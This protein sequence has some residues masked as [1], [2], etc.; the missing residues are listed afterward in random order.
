MIYRFK[1][2]RGL[3]RGFFVTAI[4]LA[5]CQAAPET[6]ILKSNIIEISGLQIGM[7]ETELI[8]E[9]GEPNKIVSPKL[10]FQH[11]TYFYSGLTIDFMQSGPEVD[12]PIVVSE[13]SS[14]SSDHCLNQIVCPGDSLKSISDILGETNLVPANHGKPARLEYILPKLEGCWVWVFTEDMKTASEIRIAC[15][16]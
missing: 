5:A 7:S 6:S 12:S 14:T 16:P 4:L 3:F 2:D 10:P 15:Q 1:K 9:L 11:T 13:L 8:N